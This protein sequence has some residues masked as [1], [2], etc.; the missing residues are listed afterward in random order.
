VTVVT[1]LVSPDEAESLTLAAT[2]GKIQ[3][4]L[5]NMLDIDS[6]STRG[7][8]IEGLVNVGT[9]RAT[10]TSTPPRAPAPEPKVVET[11]KGGNRTLVK[12]NSR[13]R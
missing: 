1:L 12:F 13:G 8:R 5:R 3:L 11:Y 6:V 9:R 2:E 10:T 4:A 7:M